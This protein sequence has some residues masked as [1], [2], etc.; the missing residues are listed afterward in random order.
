MASNI[1]VFIDEETN[2][3][4]KAC[5]A[6]NITKEGLA[7][8]VDTELQKF[9]TAVGTSC[10][11]CS[12]EQIIPCPTNIYCNKR[13]RNYCPFHKSQKQ[14]QCLTC[15]KLKKNITLYHRYKSPSW[16]NTDAKKMG[17]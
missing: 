13:K 4:F 2:N 14:Q 5:L 6:L 8:F 11:N 1:N 16:R 17:K 15:D 10:G 9:H 3:W 7:N 12:I